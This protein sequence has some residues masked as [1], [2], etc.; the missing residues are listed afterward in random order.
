MQ[1]SNISSNGIG[2]G[3]ASLPF[4]IVS[5]ILEISANSYSTQHARNVCLVSRSIYTRCWPSLHRIIALRNVKQ[6]RDFSES[7]YQL[8]VSRKEDQAHQQR[9]LERRQDAIQYLYL[10]N[11]RDV[12][13]RNFKMEQGP[14]MWMLSII[15]AARNLEVLHVEEFWSISFPYVDLPLKA[16]Y[17]IAC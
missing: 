17:D 6:L 2:S 10:N 12:N 4:E 1:Q 14:E 8:D 13:V 11:N 16:N 15:L 7:I 5:D 9:R 3:G